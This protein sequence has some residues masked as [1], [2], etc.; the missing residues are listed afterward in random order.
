MTST[1]D[2]PKRHKQTLLLWI[3]IYPTITTVLWLLLPVLQERFPLPVITLIVTVIV[4]PLMS[5]VVMPFLQKRFG[6][7]VQR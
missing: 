1:S 4:V 7:W 3:G 5:Y 6:T 2:A